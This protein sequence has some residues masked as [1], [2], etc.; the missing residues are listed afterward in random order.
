MG[1]SSKPSIVTLPSCEKPYPLLITFLSERFPAI[2]KHVWIERMNAGLLTYEGGELISQLTPYIPRRRLFYYR[3]IA[4][5]P[6]IP[7]IEKIVYQDEHLL[8]A[9]KPHFLPVIPAGRF[10]SESLLDR[11]H[12]MTGCDEITPINRIDRETAGLVMF[13]LKKETRG[14]YQSLFMNGEV[15]KTYYAVARS[16][17]EPAVDRWSVSNRIEKGHPWFRMQ[18]VDGVANAHSEI[19][20][21]DHNQSRALFRLTPVTGKKHQ[22]RLHMASIGYPILNDPL[23]PELTPESDDDYSTPLQLLAHSLSF[24]DP[25]TGKSQFAETT[26]IL[27]L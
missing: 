13:S 27:S 4:D 17:M 26:R 20:L 18:I 10:V 25:L 6:I 2:G 5:E 12:R 9:C 14:A 3:E 11:L 1:R 21:V 16:Q 7:F 24:K 19:R 22:L 8:I 15:K 23:Y